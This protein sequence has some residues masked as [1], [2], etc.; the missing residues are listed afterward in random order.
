M[1]LSR[2]IWLVLLSFLPAAL[3]GAEPATRPSILYCLADD[4]GWPHAG[5]YGD[6]VVKTPNFD[7]LAREGVLFTHAFS[8]S[9]SCT[10]SRAAML[11]GQAPH[12]L[13]EGANLWGSLPKDFPVYTDLLQ[14]N[15]YFVGLSRKGWGPGD[16]E[17]GGYSE[18]PAGKTY[19]N[20]QNFFSKVPKGK[21]FCYWFGSHDPHREYVKGSGA[22]AGLNAANVQVPP[23]FPDTPEVR[24]DILDYYFAVQRFDQELGD[25]LQ[26]LEHAGQ[27]ENTLLVVTGDN[28]MPFPRCKA[29]LYDGGTRQPLAVRWGAKVKGGRTLDDFI[30]LTDLAPTFLEAAGLKPPLQVTGRSFLGLLTGTEQPGTR[31]VVFVERERHANVRK[32]DLGYP[33]RAIRTRDFLYIWN[34][35]P[36][37]WPAGDPEKWKAVDKFGDCDNGPTKTEILKNPGDKLFSLAFGKR[38]EEELYDLKGDPYQMQNVAADASYT[39]AKKEMRN[40]LEKW[41]TDTKDPR[42]GGKGDEFEKYTYYGPIQEH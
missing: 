35:R 27:L 33:S 42:L 21:P 14:K 36:D 26:L 22:K 7:R 17:P 11:T 6:R 16:Y 1:T 4:W 23:W 5:A 40:R 37:R 41:M 24:N 19:N 32:G 9:P 3:P 8:A 31:D 18:N 29:N 34:L 10:P 12:R 13:R 25:I 15:G 2:R 39:A 38:P 30:N 28:G 20:F